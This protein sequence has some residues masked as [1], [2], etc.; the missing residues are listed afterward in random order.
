MPKIHVLSDDMANRI[1]AGE[2]VERPA[3]VVKELVENSLDAGA[4]RIAIDVEEGGRRLI[5]VTDNGEGMEPEDARNCLLRHATSKLDAQHDLDAIR[6]LGFRGEALPSIA[7]VSRLTLETQAEGAIGAAIE[8]AG[9]QIVSQREAA[10]PRGAQIT[11][12]D[13]FFNVP[14]RRKFLRSESHELSQITTVATHYALSFPE[15]HFTLRSGQFEALA[16]PATGSFRDRIFQIFGRDLLDDLV[17][18]RRKFGRSGMETHLFT[19]RPQIQKLNRNSMFFF[20]NRRLVRDKIIHHAIGEAYRNILPAGTFPVTILFLTI[21]FGDVDVN[22]HPAK[23]EVRFKHQ[24]FVHDAIRDAILGG[25]TEDK[26]IVPMETAAPQSSPF[27]APEVQPR[28]PESWTESS[29][30]ARDPFSLDNMRQPVEGRQ[31]PLAM[32]FSVNPIGPPNIPPVPETFAPAPG[33]DR[34]QQEIRPLGQL[35]SSYIVAADSSGVVLIDQH[36]AHERVLFEAY[37]RQKLAGTIEIQR[38]LVPIIVQLPPRQL[39]ILDN[40][41]PELARNGFDVEPFGPKTVAIKAAP[42]ILKPNEVETLLVELLDN[43][44]R[45]TQA[46][47][48]AAL[49]RKIAASVS[50]HAAIKINTPLDDTKMKWLVA[51][52][53]K[54]DVPTVCPHG[55]PI[56]LRYDLKEIEKGFKRA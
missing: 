6:T 29:S 23:T 18:S 56:V 8:I 27:S 35:R 13:L 45:E 34:I 38:L 47:D 54:T 1:A 3:S 40:I 14:A 42:A 16:A 25:L 9:G 11:V 44:E 28:V 5:R 49:Q 2:V 33:F 55:R 41:V 10:F 26:T 15:V 20:V 24:S 48:I 43:L 51:E 12:E 21:P 17:E 22:V 7:S 53:M 46:M 4:T 30:I 32:G 37:L 50:C 52:L 36:V 19:S 39:A 31:Q